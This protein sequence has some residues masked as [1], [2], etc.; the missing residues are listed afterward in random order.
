MC[1]E[2]LSWY[3][4]VYICVACVEPVKDTVVHS[5][6]PGL[7]LTEKTLKAARGCM[8]RGGQSSFPASGSGRVG[9]IS[10]HDG[11]GGPKLARLGPWS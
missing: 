9:K 1:V 2:F 6:G 8:G 3:R 10:R 4:N 11:L 7:A 5:A